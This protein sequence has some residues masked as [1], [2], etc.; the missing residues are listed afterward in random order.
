MD[1]LNSLGINTNELLTL[2]FL[3]VVGFILFVVMRFVLRVTRTVLRW[4]CLTLVL[5]GAAMLAYFWLT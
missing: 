5:L 2:L 3:I 1:F 4:G